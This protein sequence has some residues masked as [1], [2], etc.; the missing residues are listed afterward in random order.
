MRLYQQNPARA[1]FLGTIDNLF[2]GMQTVMDSTLW[3]RIGSPLEGGPFD[4]IEALE[5]GLMARALGKVF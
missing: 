2:D 1:L 4:A 3:N 5:S